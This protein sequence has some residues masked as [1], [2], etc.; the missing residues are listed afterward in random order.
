MFSEN[1]STFPGPATSSG[2]CWFAE[3]VAGEF[4]GFERAVISLTEMVSAITAAIVTTTTFLFIIYS[5]G[6]VPSLP[7]FG[8]VGI[9]LA[10]CAS[11]KKPASAFRRESPSAAPWV[12]RS[13]RLQCE[14]CD[15]RTR[16]RA[17]RG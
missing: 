3:A 6:N 2:T 10:N 16:A 13:N 11:K 12:V 5:T 17:N 1:G 14:C 4:A 9:T 7:S 15:R 8:K